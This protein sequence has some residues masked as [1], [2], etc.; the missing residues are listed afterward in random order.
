MPEIFTK[1]GNA[2]HLELPKFISTVSALLKELKNK[3][4]LHNNLQAYDHEIQKKAGFPILKS[5]VKI[6]F[7]LLVRNHSQELLRRYE[8][9]YLAWTPRDKESTDG[10]ATYAPHKTVIVVPERK[11]TTKELYS[12]GYRE[13]VDNCFDLQHPT[14]P[15]KPK[16]DTKTWTVCTSAEAMIRKLKEQYSTKKYVLS[17]KT[18]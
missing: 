11:Q 2:E 9:L 3:D 16:T 14:E 4:E 10:S 13:V 12:G 8:K 1:G 6:A 18:N 15:G 5:A 7:L 17:E